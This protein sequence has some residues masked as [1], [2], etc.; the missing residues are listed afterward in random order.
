MMPFFDHYFYNNNNNN[1]IG[2]R[3]NISL[4]LDLT[5]CKI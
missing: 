3:S 2:R 5:F 4:W 1:N